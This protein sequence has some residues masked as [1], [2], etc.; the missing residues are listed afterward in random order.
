MPFIY[1]ILPKLEDQYW[2]NTTIALCSTYLM[3]VFH[4]SS[5]EILQTFN[6]LSLAL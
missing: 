5:T 1:L 6:M 2:K 4:N 3:P